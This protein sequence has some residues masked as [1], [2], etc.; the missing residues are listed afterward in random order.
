MHQK[1]SSFTDF[2]ILLILCTCFSCKTEP[3]NNVSKADK[4]PDAIE[5]LKDYKEPSLQWG[6]IDTKGKLIIESK[7]DDLRDFDKGLAIANYKGKWGFINEAGT[8]VIQPL[9]LDAHNFQDSIALVQAFNKKYFY[10][11]KSGEKLFDCPSEICKDFSNGYAV[12]HQE[13][14]YGI[15]DAKGNVTCKLSYQEITPLNNNHFVALQSNKYGIINHQGQWVLKPEYDQIKNYEDGMLK[16]KKE[17]KIYFL[18]EKFKKVLGPFDGATNFAN[19]HASIIKDEKSYII[20]KKGTEIYKSLGS[21]S[22]GGENKWIETLNG[23][24]RVIDEKGNDLIGQLFDNVYQFQD[25]VTGFQSG[26]GWGYVSDKGNIIVNPSL[27]IIWSSSEKM[28][29]FVAN[30]GYGFMSNTGKLAVAPKYIEA[31]DFKNGKARVAF[32]KGE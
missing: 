14:A 15:M 3:A 8:Y 2:I 16:V 18:D 31:R 22:Y 19:G 17:N 28:I 5:W 20:D 13:D 27:P 11:N 6:F 30:S 10:I 32:P 9:Y 26:E 7:Y 23:K 21:I 25:G 12:F 4:D 1:V 24:S 29:R